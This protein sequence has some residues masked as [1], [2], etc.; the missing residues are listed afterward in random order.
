MRQ[1]IQQETLRKSTLTA[2]DMQELA[3]ELA[4]Q[5]PQVGGEAVHETEDTPQAQGSPDGPGLAG[6][7]N[8]T[9]EVYSVGKYRIIHDTR[10]RASADMKS[11][12]VQ[13]V[14][15]DTVADIVKTAVCGT[16]IRGMLKSG[17]WITLKDTERNKE[18]VV[19]FENSE[20]EK[21]TPKKVT[22]R[23]RAFSEPTDHEEVEIREA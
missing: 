13:I 3:E 12:E 9:T 4:A 17:G 21:Q 10:A 2:D 6:G 22:G 23:Q 19:P 5:Q 8:N 7:T 11:E 1:A 15:V 18:F 14:H 16:R 20:P